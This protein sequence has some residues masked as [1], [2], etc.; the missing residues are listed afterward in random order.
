MSRLE[1][2][3]ARG[4][5][6]IHAVLA[7]SLTELDTKKQAPEPAPTPLGECAKHHETQAKR[8]H[9]LRHAAWLEGDEA[10]EKT[11]AHW[12]TKHA[13]FAVACREAD[14]NDQAQRPRT[15][16]AGPATEA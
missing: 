11:M 9:E 5:D 15:K 6:M 13:G 7:R 12:E 3:T 2:D 14:G 4:I 10:M 16:G 1:Q 8:F